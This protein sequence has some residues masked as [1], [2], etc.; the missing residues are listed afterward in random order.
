MINWLFSNLSCDEFLTPKIQG[1]VKDLHSHWNAASAFNNNE[2]LAADSAERKK[3]RKEE[4]EKKLWLR[5]PWT[6]KGLEDFKNHTAG[7]RHQHFR[8]LPLPFRK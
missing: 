8:A 2:Q 1:M 6:T 4:A 3:K 7:K 5:V